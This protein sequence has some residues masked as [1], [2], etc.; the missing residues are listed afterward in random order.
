MIYKFIYD[1]KKRLNIN[2]PLGKFKKL[3]I[4]EAGTKILLIYDKSLTVIELPATY[5]KFDQYD[6]SKLNIICKYVC[7]IF[8]TRTI[9]SKN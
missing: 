2:V 6:G 9:I 4:N 1:F 3:L 8:L 7:N 5:G